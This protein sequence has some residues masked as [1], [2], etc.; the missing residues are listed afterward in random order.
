MTNAQ[1][2]FVT[3]FFFFAAKRELVN[4]GFERRLTTIDLK[5]LIENYD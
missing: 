2:Y 4:V 3:S 5:L 1:K